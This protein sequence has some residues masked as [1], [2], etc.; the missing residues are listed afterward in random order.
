[1]IAKSTRCLHDLDVGFVGAA[2]RMG[3]IRQAM[4]GDRLLSESKKTE[5]SFLDQSNNAWG[6]FLPSHFGVR[7]AA[8]ILLHLSHS[9]FTVVY[10]F[11]LGAK[12]DCQ[13]NT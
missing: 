11:H 6:G 5:R 12:T 3:M 9:N 10:I 8:A 7:L 2:L 4:T 13:W 1:M